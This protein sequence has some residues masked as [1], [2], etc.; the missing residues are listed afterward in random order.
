M[1]ITSKITFTLKMR[2]QVMKMKFMTG[3]IRLLCRNSVATYIFKMNFG[4]K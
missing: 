4:L 2:V 3:L 1:K